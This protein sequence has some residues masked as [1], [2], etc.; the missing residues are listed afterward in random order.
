MDF[1]KERKAPLWMGNYT[2]I[3]MLLNENPKIVGGA[4][5]GCMDRKLG[6]TWFVFREITRKCA[7]ASSFED[8]DTREK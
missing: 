8:E 1:K 7:A 6:K 5:G 3:R 2:N 4:E